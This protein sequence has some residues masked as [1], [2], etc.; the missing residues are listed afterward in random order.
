VSTTSAELPAA[1]AT[2]AI[3]SAMRAVMPSVV[4]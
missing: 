4:A 1:R 2:S 3:F